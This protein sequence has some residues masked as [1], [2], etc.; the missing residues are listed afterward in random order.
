LTIDLDL[1]EQALENLFS[2]GYNFA[3]FQEANRHEKAERIYQK[4]KDS[5][6]SILVMVQEG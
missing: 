5:I 1:L 2:A 4:A 6:Q 3:V